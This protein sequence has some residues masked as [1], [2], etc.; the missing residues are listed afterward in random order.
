MIELKIVDKDQIIIT[1]YN[2]S[3]DG[4]EAKELETIYKRKN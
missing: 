2:I 4:E 3:P 1:A